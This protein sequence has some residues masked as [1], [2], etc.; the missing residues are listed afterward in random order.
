MLRQAMTKN[1][2]LRV[3]VADGYYDL[4][5]PFCATDYSIDHLLLEPALVSNI[6]TRH[7]EAGH[8]M[9]VHKGAHEQLH[10]DLTKFYQT[11]V[12]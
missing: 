6:T 5:T 11:A 8:M 1:P 3:F 4:A 7:Y 2:E 9:Y 12:R 10:K